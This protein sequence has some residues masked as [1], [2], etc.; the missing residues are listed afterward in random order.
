VPAG[1]HDDEHTSGFSMRDEHPGFHT[2]L[3]TE[4]E[5]RRSLLKSLIPIAA[6]YDEGI[7]RLL[8][9]HPPLVANDD[10]DWM[11]EQLERE[12]QKHLRLAGASCRRVSLKMSGKLT[13][14]AIQRNRLADVVGNFAC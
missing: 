7:S 5:K 13:C 1:F 12:E 10:L 2:G 6:Q 9:S 11:I 4:P 14:K 3:Q 8:Y